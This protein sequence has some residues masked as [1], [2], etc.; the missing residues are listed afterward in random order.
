LLGDEKFTE[1]AK[2]AARATL[3]RSKACASDLG[4][5][6]HVTRNIIVYGHIS[7]GD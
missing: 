4:D 3:A 1:F 6:S 5:G 2:C 7:F